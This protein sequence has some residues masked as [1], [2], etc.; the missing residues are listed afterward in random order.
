MGLDW[1]NPDNGATIAS[2]NERLYRFRATEEGVFLLF[3]PNGQSIPT[4]QSDFYLFGAVNVQPREAEWYRSQV[5][6][7][8]LVLATY[9][10]SAEFQKKYWPAQGG[11]VCSELPRQR[12]DRAAGRRRAAP[13]VAAGRQPTS[14]C[15]GPGP[16]DPMGDRL[17]AARPTR[18]SAQGG[19]G[20]SSTS[21]VSCRP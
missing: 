5:I 20:A 8:D 6:R 9:R 21:R 18:S 17:P 7:E 10:T 1:L 13:R 3:S 4:S 15:P 16:V 12:R 19:F 11:K 2:G 14:T